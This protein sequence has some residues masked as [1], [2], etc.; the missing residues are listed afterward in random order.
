MN[1][2]EQLEQQLLAM[3]AELEELKR[4]KLEASEEEAVKA[5][6]PEQGS[7]CLDICN[8]GPSETDL[9]FATNGDQNTFPDKETAEAYA[10][11]FRV[12]LELRRQPRSGQLDEEGGRVHCRH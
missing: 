2:I 11:A 9:L 3:Q 7:W 4:T 6:L 10:D 1:K 8:F 5:M 12:M